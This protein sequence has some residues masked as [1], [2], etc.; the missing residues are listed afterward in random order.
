MSGRMVPGLEFG[1]GSENWRGTVSTIG[2]NN[3]YYYHS[4][5]TANFFRAWKAGELFWGEIE[6]GVGGGMNYA[7]RGFKDEGGTEETQKSDVVVGPAFFVQWQL[8]GPVYLKID[9]LWGLRSVGQLVGLNGQDIIFI[10]L[11][12]RAW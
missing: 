5:Y 11:G 1:L 4:S 7:V 6:S 12:G 2:V 10:S 9:M 3:G 8:A